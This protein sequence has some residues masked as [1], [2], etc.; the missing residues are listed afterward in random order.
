MSAP[1]PLQSSLLRVH[2]HM[3]KRCRAGKQAYK[4]KSGSKHAGGEFCEVMRTRGGLL[5]YAGWLTTQEVSEE[6]AGEILA[7]TEDSSGGSPKPQ[8]ERRRERDP[9]RRSGEPTN[10]GKEHSTGS[11]GMLEPQAPSLSS[12]RPLFVETGE[13]QGGGQGEGQGDGD[14]EGAGK[15]SCQNSML[16]ILKAQGA[17]APFGNKEK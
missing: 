7:A 14:G 5:S 16:A 2:M 8:R 1:A 17:A 6:E 3:Y 13:G 10:S 12:P 15:D 11:V 9:L 4:H